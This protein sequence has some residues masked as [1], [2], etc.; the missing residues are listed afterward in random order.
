MTCTPPPP[1]ATAVT[2][3]LKCPAAAAGMCPLR[4][5]ALGEDAQGRPSRGARRQARCLLQQIRELP[6]QLA[7]YVLAH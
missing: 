4:G 6:G 1:G 2:G 3:G 7:S 5:A